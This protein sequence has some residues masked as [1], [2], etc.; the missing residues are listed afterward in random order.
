ME[1]F[2]ACSQVLF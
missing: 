2:L 1:V